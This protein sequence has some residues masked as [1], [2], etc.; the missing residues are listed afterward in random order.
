MKIV[1]VAAVSMMASSASLIVLERCSQN[2]TFMA[3]PKA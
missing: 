3:K 1:G 2:A